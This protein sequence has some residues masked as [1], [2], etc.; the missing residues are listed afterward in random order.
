MCAIMPKKSGK[1]VLLQCAA[2]FI[3][4]A[5]PSAV[6]VDVAKSVSLETGSPERVGLRQDVCLC[7]DDGG[8]DNRLLAES[9]PPEIGLL[10]DA[11]DLCA[12]QCLRKKRSG[13]KQGCGVDYSE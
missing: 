10:A 3:G 11:I 8:R 1:A 13:D 4:I 12:C 6:Q 7:H 5:G 2:I 9:A